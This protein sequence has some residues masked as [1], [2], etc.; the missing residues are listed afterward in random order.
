MPKTLIIAEAACTWTHGGLESAYASIRAAKTCGADAWKTQFTSDPESMAMRRGVSLD[1]YQRL[2][3]A[4]D[5]LPLLKAECER[6]GIELMVT[7]F[8]PKDVAL[9][10]PY[11]SR[12]KVSAFERNDV[13]LA[14]ACKA[15]GK[16]C[17][18]SYNADV[19]CKLDEPYS[20]LYCVS[21]YPTRL[22]DLHLGVLWH[23]GKYCESLYDGLSDHTT[24]LLT[25]AVAVGA[26]ARVLEKHVKMRDCP[27]EDPDFGHSLLMEMRECE[28][29]KY[30]DFV[31]EAE[32]ML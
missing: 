24:S 2:G 30:V 19:P 6:V 23:R 27:E 21:K 15:Y 3:W 12:F 17:V 22:E 18:I 5:A 14:K 7:V 4:K 20:A 9:I 25:G 16:P 29:S 8:I 31:R 10:A 1:K 11:V 13:E 32:R 28:F 26:G